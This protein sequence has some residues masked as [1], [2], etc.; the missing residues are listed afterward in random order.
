MAAITITELTKVYE[1][2]TVAV[3]DLSLTVAEGEFLVLVGSSGCGKSTVLRCVAGLESPTSGTIALDN[4]VVNDLAPQERDLAMVFQN[5]ALYPHM[6]VYDN[7]AFGLKMRRLP[8]ADMQQRVRWVAEKLGLGEYLLKKPR[9]LSGGQQQRVALG[10]AMVRQPQAFLMDEP[11]SNLDA[12]LRVKMRGEI[13]KLQRELGVTILYVTHD[14]TEALTMGDRVAVLH[15]GRLQQVAS[16]WELYEH[17]A[18]QFVAGFIGSPA[19]N[20]LSGRLRQG[21]QGLILEFSGQT[22]PLP[23]ALVARHPALPQQVEK[24]VIIGVR[25]EHLKERGD[26]P[27]GPK[28]VSF[29]VE[30]ELVETTGPLNY[31]HFSLPDPLSPEG[32]RAPLVAS[33]EATRPMASGQVLQLMVDLNLLHFFDAASGRAI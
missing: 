10:R 22:V 3:K 7:L 33:L 1:D 31:V 18:T 8:R 15:Q 19:M 26:M 29:K 17:P 2:G 30:A 25:P 14:Q 28:V 21:P 11:L 23:E 32:D 24:T 13:L 5:F 4:Q 16:A 6:T 9:Q 27:P 20:F 12:A